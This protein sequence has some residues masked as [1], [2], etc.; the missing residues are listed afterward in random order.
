[1]EVRLDKKEPDDLKE[2]LRYHFLTVEPFYRPQ[3]QMEKAIVRALP[4]K[5][6]T[7]I[8]E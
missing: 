4:P 6:R 8:S 3:E 5:R 7:G 2:H 1:M